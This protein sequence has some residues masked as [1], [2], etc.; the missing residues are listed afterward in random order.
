MTTIAPIVYV[1]LSLSLSLSLSVCLCVCVYIYEQICVCVLSFCVYCHLQAQKVL[2]F[3]Q[4]VLRQVAQCIGVKQQ[5]RDFRSVGE[6][7]PVQQGCVSGAFARINSATTLCLPSNK[8][9]FN[10]LEQS[11]MLREAPHLDRNSQ[12]SVTQFSYCIKQLESALSKI[13]GSP[14]RGS[15]A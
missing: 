2:T 13:G 5:L 15:W 7:C 14:P 4:N 3:L 9:G 1:C 8:R 10:V 12:N 11:Q 6:G